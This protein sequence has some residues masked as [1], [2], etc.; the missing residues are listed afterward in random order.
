MFSAWFKI[1]L[2]KRIMAML[3]LGIVFG[4]LAGEHAAKISWIG[5][6]FINLIRMIVVPL[7][8]I[9]LVSGVIAMG[10]P[11]RLGSLGIKTLM[12]Y[13]GTTLVAI[14]IGLTVAAIVQPGIGVDI[15]GAVAK[16]LPPAK[17]LA[18][19]LLSIIPTNPL[20]AL[21]DGDMLAI[22]FFA[23]ILGAGILMAGSKAKTLAKF[24]DDGSEAMLKVTHIV[25]EVAPFGV[26]AL[27]SKVVGQGG[28][29]QLFTVV[30]LAASVIAACVIHVLITHGAIMKFLL[31]LP[32]SRFFRD[33]T[34]AQLVA[35]STSSSSGTLPVTMTVAEENL[36]VSKTVASSVLPL[37]AT[38]NMDGSGIYVG[39]LAV[40][41]AQV[42]GVPL[43]L[44]QYLMI[45]FAATLVSIGTAAVPSASLFLLATVLSVI[46]IEDAQTFLIVGFVFPFDRP[47]D[48]LRTVVNVTGDL[49]VGTAVA[50]W[51]GELDEK[52]FKAEPVD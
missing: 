9:T 32:P 18:E 8:F 24:A 31:K 43:G 37:G 40:F 51:E 10:D 36:G 15:S 1:T 47:L 29:Q 5:D 38:I 23:L 44:E 39:I 14:T 21:A 46:G 6:I 30:P 25:M 26:F 48:M 7:V 16:E 49:S 17:P 3:V 50:K 20:A 34:G 4:A 52:V 12:L 35:F 11:K 45:A 2:W 22:I 28:I 41:A 33:I 13:I 42:L 19:R 27:I